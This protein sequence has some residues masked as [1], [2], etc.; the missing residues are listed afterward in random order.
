[1]ERSEGGRKGHEWRYCPKK[2]CKRTGAS[3]DGAADTFLYRR[4]LLRRRSGSKPQWPRRKEWKGGTFPLRK[5]SIS[6][7][8][9]RSCPSKFFSLLEYRLIPPFAPCLVPFTFLFCPVLTAKRKKAR[10][11]S[12]RDWCL[13]R[14]P[15]IPYGTVLYRVLLGETYWREP[16]FL[17]WNG[18]GGVFAL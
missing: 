5:K 6:H 12:A 2:D 3:V 16:S 4:R 1:M 18:S 13:G 9:T 15:T 17:A 7:P 8:S 11:Y 14:Q 10:F